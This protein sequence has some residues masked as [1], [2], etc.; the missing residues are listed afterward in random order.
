MG[1][2]C[3]GRGCLSAGR[4]TADWLFSLHS[5][6][7]ALTTESAKQRLQDEPADA[8]PRLKRQR[9]SGDSTSALLTPMPPLQLP[10]L[11]AA[12]AAEAAGSGGFGS[13]GFGSGTVAWPFTSAELL[14]GDPGGSGSIGGAGTSGSMLYHVEGTLS[15]GG[16]YGGMLLPMHPSAL[17]SAA[18]A[19]A[20]AAAA[21]G[22]QDMLAPGM[23][24]AAAALQATTGGASLAE[25]AEAAGAAAAEAL[26]PVPVQ[27]SSRWGRMGGWVDCVD[28]L[29]WQ[30]P[31]CCSKAA[32]WPRATALHNLPLPQLQI[33]G[34]VHVRRQ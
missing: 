12:A 14:S 30:S 31:A 7:P 9:V 16:L 26:H 8:L 17:P 32:T 29:A 28:G 2:G 6:A 34:R 24:A 22:D 23:A 5:P 13:G 20:A 15:E 10:S 21:G 27:K 18:A 4:T 3:S 33:P 1:V 25:A 11:S 19:A